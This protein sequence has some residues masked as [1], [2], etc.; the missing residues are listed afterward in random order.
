MSDLIEKIL[1]Y[2]PKYF[3]ELSQCA[4]TPKAF[5]AEKTK[6]E[7]ALVD[8]LLFVGI[9]YTLLAVVPIPYFQQ[10][11]AWTTISFIAVKSGIALALLIP[12]YRFIWFL[13]G[14]RGKSSAFFAIYLYQNGVICIISMLFIFVSFGYLFWANTEIA[15]EVTALAQR[16]S[17]LPDSYLNRNEVMIFGAL[18][19]LG[20]AVVFGWLTGAYGAYRQLFQMGRGR[21][22]FIAIITVVL[23]VPSYFLSLWITVAARAL[24]E[25]TSQ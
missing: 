6:A 10:K 5:F 22:T 12:V 2:L 17:P 1:S 19:A 16:G 18:Q 11:T 20:V 9:T 24:F 21:S 7:S 3:V 4:V 8:A 15:R 14:A 13:F 25:M 23:F